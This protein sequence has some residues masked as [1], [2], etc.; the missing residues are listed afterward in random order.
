MSEEDK[1]LS[2]LE[3]AEKRRAERKAKANEA[4][5]AQRAIDT[6]KISDLE[7]TLGDAKIKAIDVPFYT[8]M[9]AKVAV[10]CPNAAEVKRYRDRV[11]TRKNGDPGDPVAANEEVGT[12]CV[13]YPER[14]SFLAL[15]EVLPG[16]LGQCGAEAMHLAVGEAEKEGKG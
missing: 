1:T 7:E 2:P 9:V 14:E 11:K 16:L 13:V 8:G 12:S 15:C 4:R 5:D 6:D 3:A 10:R